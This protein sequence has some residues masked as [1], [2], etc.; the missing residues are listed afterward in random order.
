[1]ASYPFSEIEL[2]YEYHPIPPDGNSISPF[3]SI[4]ILVSLP[5]YFC[6]PESILNPVPVYHE[7]ESPI[8]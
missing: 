1:L 6:I 8:S 3:D 5:Y 4:M 2:E 7:L